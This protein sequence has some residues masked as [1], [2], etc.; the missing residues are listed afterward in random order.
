[1]VFT[2][3]GVKKGEYLVGRLPG[4]RAWSE[5]VHQYLVHPDGKKFVMLKQ[6]AAYFV[7]MP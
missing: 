7:T 6:D 1:M 2:L 3:H 5:G 4:V